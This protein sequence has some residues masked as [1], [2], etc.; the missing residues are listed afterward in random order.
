M[1]KEG[2]AGN[3]FVCVV[4]IVTLL[5]PILIAA[6]APANSPHFNNILCEPDA[7]V[8][9]GSD[10][11]P[12]GRIA[13]SAD[14]AGSDLGPDVVEDI[15]EQPAS[16]CSWD[17]VSSLLGQ[18]DGREYLRACLLDIDRFLE[19][20]QRDQDALMRFWVGLG[21]ERTM[22]H[23]YLA[24]FEAWA[25]EPGRE[26]K[27]ISHA[28]NELAFF[29]D[30]AGLYA[31][32]E[33]LLRRALAISERGFGTDHPKVATY[34][35][36]LG[37]VLLTT[38]RPAEAEPLMRRALASV[39]GGNGVGRANVA[40]V[41]NNLAGVLQATGRQGEADSLLRRALAIEEQHFGP[42]HPRVARRLHNLA[43]VFQDTN[44]PAE[45]E[46]LYRRAWAIWDKS[47]GAEHPDTI[48]GLFG[49]AQLLRDTGSHVEAAALYGRILEAG[50]TVLE[51][52]EVP[53]R[54]NLEVVEVVAISHNNLAYHT[55]VPANEWAEAETH[56]QRSYALFERLA[57]PVEVANVGL[58]LQALYRLAGRPLDLGRIREWIRILED[59]DDPRSGKGHTLLQ[60]SGE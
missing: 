27:D 50:E 56:Y 9:R 52:A 58:N 18:A 3:S 25:G 36:N 44:R 60:L 53:T 41:L 16:D 54:P 47:L 45:A 15:E 30:A 26:D 37:M 48:R 24:A 6:S 49:L 13:E 33:L 31:E 39:E 28:A 51:R 12:A 42:D 19:I 4:A 10:E 1:E 17:D 20:Y 14:A 43:G 8:R 22:G 55:H 5:I 59:S 2:P 40:T 29:L 35:N 21:E 23:A 11:R 32:V 34:L 57:K 38:N 7:S 46:S